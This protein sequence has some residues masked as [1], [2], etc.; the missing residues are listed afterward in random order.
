MCHSFCSPLTPNGCDCFGCCELPAGS[1]EY[2]FL[3]T[4]GSDGSPTCTLAAA[5]AGDHTACHP[6]TPVADCL[7][8]CDHCELCLGRTTLPPDCFPPPPPPP[9][10]DAGHYP[11]GGVIPY[12]AGPTPPDAATP[13]AATPD[14]GPPPPPRCGTGIQ[15]CGLPTDP[16]CPTGQYCITGCCVVFG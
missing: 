9:P 5:E 8:T 16:A 2:V 7:N 10:V 6:C 1:G 13:D 12:D 11:D 4:L 3:G 14:A 15:P